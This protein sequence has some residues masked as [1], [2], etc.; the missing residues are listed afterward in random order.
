MWSRT[1]KNYAAAA[2]GL[3]LGKQSQWQRAAPGKLG[4]VSDDLSQRAEL[5]SVLC[6]SHR[7]RQPYLHFSEVHAGGN[8]HLFKELP[9]VFDKVKPKNLHDVDVQDPKILS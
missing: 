6:A 9:Q 7:K 8:L 1:P 5:G 4:N 2:L 3:L